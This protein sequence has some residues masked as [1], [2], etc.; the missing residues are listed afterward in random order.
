MQQLY[1][2]VRQYA[3]NVV[4]VGGLNYAFDL[5]GVAS[6]PVQGVNIMYATHPYDYSGKQSGDWDAAF[7]YLTATYPVIMTEFGQY[8]D[9]DTYVSDLLT[10]AQGKN[11]HWTAWAW[12]VQDCSFPSIVA[13]WNGTPL[14]TVGALVK[15][16]LTAGA[17]ATTTQAPATTTKAPTTAPTSTTTT[18]APTSAPTTAKGATTAPTSA[19]TTAKANSTTTAPTTTKAPS[20]TGCSLTVTFSGGTVYFNNVGTLTI[21]AATFTVT[22]T[23]SWNNL[24]LVSGTTFSFPSWENALAA[25]QS[26]SSGAGYNGTPPTF[27][28]IVASC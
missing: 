9:T 23:L 8:C 6:Y 11:I 15:Q 21:K 7:G 24:Q 17:A 16:Y 2:A 4:I 1:N 13:D 14:G 18:K 22:G 28:N 5:S 12:W 3:T 25:G 10:Y 19:P 26:W 27:T 20:T